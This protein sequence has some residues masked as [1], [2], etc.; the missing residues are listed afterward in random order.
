MS[1]FPADYNPRDPVIAA[2]DLCEIDTPDGPARFMVG[3]DAMFVD[4]N[5]NEWWG[6]QLIGVTSLSA[7]IDGAAPEGNVTLSYFQ[8]PNADNLVGQVRELGLDY[9]KGRPITF[10]FQPIRSQAEFMKPTTPPIQYMQRTMRTITTSRTGAQDR[11]ISLT[12]EAWS[13]QRRAARRIVLNTE[14]HSKL[15]GVDNPSLEKMPTTDFEEQK[16]FG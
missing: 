7:A 11:S 2:L 12:F 9:V 10:Y 6:S 5:Q 14:G 4:V 15:L 13:E 1:F 8:D 16:L 3:V